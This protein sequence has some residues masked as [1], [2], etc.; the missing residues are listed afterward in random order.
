MKKAWG[1]KE[2]RQLEEI[3]IIDIIEEDEMLVKWND[4]IYSHHYRYTN[5][6][7]NSYLGKFPRRSCETVFAMYLLNVTA[8]GK[9]GFYSGMSWSDI[10]SL[11]NKLCQIEK[12]TSSDKN[13]PLYYTA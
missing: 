7:F 1:N 13:L 10:F 8:E 5:G 9:K 11:V 4:F 12:K 2:N 3:S 6:F